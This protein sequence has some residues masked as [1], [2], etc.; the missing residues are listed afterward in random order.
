[1]HAPQSPSRR[2]TKNHNHTIPRGTAERTYLYIEQHSARPQKCRWAAFTPTLQAGASFCPDPN[3]MCV[4]IINLQWL[5]CLLLLP[6]SSTEQASFELPSSPWFLL[7]FAL[8]GDALD[9]VSLLKHS[10]TAKSWRT[11]FGSD[12]NNLL[13]LFRD[14]PGKTHQSGTSNH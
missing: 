11:R 12:A 4:G 14:S 8:D 10:H 6:E 2:L 3:T 13:T 7:L 5:F 9:V 1:M